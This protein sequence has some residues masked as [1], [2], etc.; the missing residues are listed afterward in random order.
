MEDKRMTVEEFNQ[1]ISEGIEKEFDIRKCKTF[2][3]E[4]VSYFQANTNGL[5]FFQEVEILKI[6]GKDYS[7]DCYL[8]LDE[9]DFGGRVHECVYSKYHDNAMVAYHDKATKVI[10]MVMNDELLQIIK[11]KGFEVK[12]YREVGDDT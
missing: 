5:G 11:D 7:K 12:S 6:D 8:S 3:F 4:S 1:L 9:M 10:A 2:K